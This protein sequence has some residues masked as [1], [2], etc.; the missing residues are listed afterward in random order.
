MGVKQYHKLVR[1]KI[2]E[3][4]LASGK[5][6]ICRKADREETL[7]LLARKLEEEAAE[8]AASRDAE[9]LCDVL[10]VIRAIAAERGIAL[11]ALE[12][13]RARKAAERGGFEK[14]IVLE[15]VHIPDGRG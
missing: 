15:E 12:Q 11:E 7:E 5:E 10:E 8:Y 2:P 13:E 14:R 6:P 4:I 1:D 9:E 3:M